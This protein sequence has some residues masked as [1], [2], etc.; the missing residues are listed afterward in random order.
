MLFYTASAAYANPKEERK[1]SP[2]TPS[3][4]PL[5]EEDFRVRLLNPKMDPR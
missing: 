5:K 1:A 4:L 2:F 3:I